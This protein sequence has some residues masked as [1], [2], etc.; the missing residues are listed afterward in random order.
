MADLSHLERMGR[1]LKCPICLGLL[2][3]AVSLT[4]N[5]AFCNSC[6]EKSMKSAL[7]C[8]VCKVPYRR[9]EIR[10]A[11]HMDNLVS[12]YKSMEVA[13]GV[14][15]FITQNA[16]STKI[17]GEDNQTDVNFYEA[18]DTGKAQLGT[19]DCED[20]KQ[21][22]TRRSKRASMTK[23]R[24]F[25]SS[26]VKPSFPNKKRVQVP[27]YPTSETQMQHEKPGGG[28]GE[29]EGNKPQ[30][31]PVVQKDVPSICEKREPILS[32]FFWLREEADLEKSSQQTDGNQ[33]MYTPPETLCFSDIKDSDDDVPVNI[34]P[35]R[36]TGILNS[37]DFIDS[38]MF[39]WT[40]RPCS[41]ELCSSPLVVQPIMSI[42]IEDTAEPSGAQEKAEAA[43]TETATGLNICSKKRETKGKRKT[44][45]TSGNKGSMRSSNKRA[46]NATET[47]ISKR[48][49]NTLCEETAVN[50]ESEKVTNQNMQENSGSNKKLTNKA[51]T[52]KNK[53]LCPEG[54]VQETAAEKVLTLSDGIK[55]LPN[56]NKASFI[57]FSASENVITSSEGS[58]KLKKCGQNGKSTIKTNAP[59]KK[60]GDKIK[61]GK[62][63]TENDTMKEQSSD[64]LIS[65]LNTNVLPVGNEKIPNSGM[66][67]KTCKEDSNNGGMTDEICEEDSNKMPKSKKVKFSV[68]DIAKNNSES[69]PTSGNEFAMRGQT[70]QDIQCPISQPRKKISAKLD[71]ATPTL[72]DTVLLKCKT[73]PSPI[74]CAFCQSSKESEASGIMVHYFNGKLVADSDKARSNSVHVH[75]NCTE[76]APNV[77]F[78][79]DNVMNL[80]NEL[81]R[82]R[83]IRCSC[84][85]MKG[86]A[87]GCYEKSCR[88]S[89]HVPCARLTPECRWDYENF[90]MLCPFHSSC[91][92]PNEITKSQSKQKRK[93]ATESKSQNHQAK[94]TDEC[95]HILTTQWKAQKKSKN[96]VLCYSA[97]SNTEKD[98]LNE[99]EKMSGVT[100][101][102]NWDSSVTHVIASTDE[103]GACRRTLKFLM[104]VLEGKWIL[105]IQWFKACME[106]G[107]LVDEQPY[108]IAVDIHGI[109]DGPRLGRLRHPMKRPKLFDGYKFFFMGDFAPSYKGYL[110]DLV[111]A[112]GGKV[113]N[114]KPVGGDQPTSSSGSSATT[115][116][117]YSLEL[118]E[119]CKQSKASS[120]LNSRRCDA[121]AL[122]RSTG[123]V[124]ASN[125]WILNSIAGYKL[126]SLGE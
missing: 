49:K 105:S 63:Q 76:W 80:E 12:V 1:E 106:A 102:K 95:T 104:G 42:Q 67:R 3:S 101:L 100:I 87:L 82:S 56:S 26:S 35:K 84:C 103:N 17:S 72:N 93:Y 25:G 70:F 44:T 40:Q 23:Q 73:F 98:L 64:V 112:A 65:H 121:E 37:T 117:V 109:R 52:R 111:I 33:D 118:P 58:S 77:Y 16:A 83:R 92:L 99:F 9:R 55:P 123:S 34:S 53:K 14:N 86:A 96:L 114:R 48:I 113:L 38:E 20:Q 108:E 18:R 119:K 68:E 116:I 45:K 90:V 5:H 19:L 74:Q 8:P 89:F 97:L 115:F 126:Q 124:A 2:N 122:A 61:A 11:P 51:I 107:E 36:G 7:N 125:S 13:S 30:E 91:Q 78:E 110:H 88:K 120:V 71:N 69:L 31:C 79:D 46:T 10:P 41:P 81:S 94:T 60:F 85:G 50:N 32:P 57:D 24:A 29:I 22:R 47:R 66:T 59:Q 4:C 15:I 27:Q 62:Y 21:S 75:K 6:I 39:D 43:S 28:I 54:G